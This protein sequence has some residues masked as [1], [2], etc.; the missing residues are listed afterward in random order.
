MHYHNMSNRFNN[1][2]HCI[3]KS[4]LGV[5]TGEDFL[6]SP[7]CTH[8][9]MTQVHCKATQLLQTVL[10]NSHPPVLVPVP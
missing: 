1:I 3:F 7:R 4:F 10:D 2:V 6:E 8:R 5:T 9:T